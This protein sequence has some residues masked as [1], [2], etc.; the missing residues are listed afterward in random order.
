MSVEYLKQIR[1]HEEKADQIRRDGLAESRRIARA[2]EEEAAALIDRA[3]SEADALY[4]ETLA[5]AAA[6]AA[7]DYDNIIQQARWECDM[8]LSHAEKQS[9]KAV[10]VIVRKVIN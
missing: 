3:S 8:L 5:R 2:A 10:S 6:E 1:E 7:S 4:K 9:E